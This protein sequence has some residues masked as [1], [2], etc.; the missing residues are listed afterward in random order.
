MCPSLHP[1]TEHS[2]TAVDVCIPSYS[3]FNGYKYPLLH[4]VMNNLSTAV[5][6]YL[7]PYI[8]WCI[9]YLLHVYVCPFLHPL[10]E[11]LSAAID[12]F[13]HPYILLHQFSPSVLEVTSSHSWSL[14]N[15]LHTFCQYLYFVTFDKCL[16]CTWFSLSQE[17]NN[18]T[19]PWKSLTETI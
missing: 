12:K 13:I 6:T 11:H 17:E 7:Q 9:I 16:S 15:E 2:F 4:P 5:D 3:L 14:T 8:L 1:L 19:F 18:V 10:I